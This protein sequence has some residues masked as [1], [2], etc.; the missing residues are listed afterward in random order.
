MSTRT[1]TVDEAMRDLVTQTRKRLIGQDAAVAAFAAE[2]CR[3]IAVSPLQRRPGIFLVAGPNGDDGDHLGLPIGLAA[4]FRESGGVYEL[5]SG[6]GEHLA[7]IFATVSGETEAWSLLG[8]VR[9]NPTAMFVLQD[10]D[11]AHPKLLETLMTA[12][13]RGFVDDGTGETIPLASSIFVLTIEVAQEAIGRI[14]RSEPAS[15]RLHVECLKA[16]LDAGFP[17]LLLKSIDTVVALKS[18][19]P[20]ETVLEHHRSFGEQV[21]SHGLVLEEGGIDGRI[22]AYSMDSSIEPTIAVA[23]LPRNEFDA[24][25]AQAKAAGVHTVRLVLG[26]GIIRVVPVGAPSVQEATDRSVNA[27]PAASSDEEA[28]D[29]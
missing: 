8:S 3:H 11:K 19:T 29:E 20:G 24:R 14:A 26:E 18:L 6:D 5:G 22:L 17:A 7:Q 16:L 27:Q 10:I 12:W 21:A 2:I 25:L 9:D 13:S 4:T 15:D 1:L 28:T 23:L